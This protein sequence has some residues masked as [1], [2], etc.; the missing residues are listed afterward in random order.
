[1]ELMKNAV[2][3]FHVWTLTDSHAYQNQKMCF[4]KL[5][6]NRT[7]NLTIQPSTKLYPSKSMSLECQKSAWDCT[8]NWPLFPT[9][10]VDY[11]KPNTE[12]S[13]KFIKVKRTECHQKFC[14]ANEIA[15]P[16]WN[17]DHN[18]KHNPVCSKLF[19]YKF[20]DVFWIVVGGERQCNH[21]S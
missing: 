10:Y 4:K 8:A 17:K 5:G 16:L 1:M 14:Q 2:Y 7:D 13:L 12:M 19:V 11:N 20:Q 18:D 21:I 6:Q 9:W 15:V 3:S